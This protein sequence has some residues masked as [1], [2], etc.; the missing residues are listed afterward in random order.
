MNSAS[1]VVEEIELLHDKYAVEALA[2]VDDLFIAN[3]KRVAEIVKELKERKLLG[4]IKY[5]VDGRANLINNEIL[6]LLKKMGV[7][8]ISIGF[9]SG[10]EKMLRYLKKNSVTLQQNIDCVKQISKAGF[11]I[12]GQFIIGSPGETKSDIEQTIDFMKNPGITTAHVSVM[13]PLPGTEIWDNYIQKNSGIDVA[14]IDWRK[15]D[16]DPISRQDD[17]VY[18]GDVP[19]KQFVGLYEKARA[20]SLSKEANAAN[21]WSFENLFKALK[22]PSLALKIV[23]SKLGLMK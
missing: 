15:F 17:S 10:S 5:L 18:V 6:A 7:V 23:L 4:E 9:E 3:K 2:V 19:F 22:N 14:E 16:M 20:V 11:N 12:Y 21:F 13:T 1:Y 8:N